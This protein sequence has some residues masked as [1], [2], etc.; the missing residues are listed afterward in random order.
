MA[1]PSA[2]WADGTEE[3]DSPPSEK[4]AVMAEKERVRARRA[5]VATFPTRSITSL[6][7]SCE[8]VFF[9]VLS[10]KRLL[11]CLAWSA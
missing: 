1:A 8:V 10:S 5:E 11:S 6:L 7:I 9:V 4:G 2:A 3:R